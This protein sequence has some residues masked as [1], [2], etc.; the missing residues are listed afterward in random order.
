MRTKITLCSFATLLFL[1]SVAYADPIP[2][3]PVYMMTE[4]ADGL[5]TD[6]P[7]ATV[8]QTTPRSWT[9]QL[10][11]NQYFVIHWA[12]YPKL[13]VRDPDST[14][15]FN[16]LTAANLPGSLHW[17][18]SPILQDDLPFLTDWAPIEIHS[19]SPTELIAWVQVQDVPN[20]V[21]DQS[22]TLPLM[23]ASLLGTA[24]LARFRR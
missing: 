19:D 4:T 15:N 3:V 9:V 16:L 20:R 24:G 5:I 12:A 13:Y 14:Q 17:L 11:A 23:M 10:S 18:K 2:P 8:T 22:A 21:P 1:G 6:I 7:G